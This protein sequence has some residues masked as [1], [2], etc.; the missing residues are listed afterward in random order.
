M[1]K[2]S[3]HYIAYSSN[4]RKEG[5]LS[6]SGLRCSTGFGSTMGF[7]SSIDRNSS[8][9]FSGGMMMGSDPSI[10]A[11]CGGRSESSGERSFSPNSDIPLENSS[12]PV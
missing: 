1:I 10:K 11:G 2:A 8:A 12:I 3:I 9:G 5:G 6:T 4:T 7:I